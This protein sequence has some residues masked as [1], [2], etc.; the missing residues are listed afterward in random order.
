MMLVLRPASKNASRLLY[1]STSGVAAQPKTAVDVNE[2]AFVPHGPPSATFR[3]TLYHAPAEQEPRR[4]L[5][6]QGQAAPVQQPPSPVLG[7]QANG[8]LAVEVEELASSSEGAVFMEESYSNESMKQQQQQHQQMMSHDATHSPAMEELAS[9]MPVQHV[10]VN[11]C[12]FDSGAPWPVGAMILPVFWP[13]HAQQP[14]Y[15]WDS[16]VSVNDATMQFDIASV[17]SQTTACSS[18]SDAGI[19]VGTPLSGGQQQCPPSGS[20]AGLPGRTGASRRQRRKQRSA[21]LSVARESVPQLDQAPATPAAAIS[22]HVSDHREAASGAATLVVEAEHEASLQSGLP[23]LHVEAAEDSG[24][25]MLWPPTPESSPQTSPRFGTEKV[26]EMDFVLPL[27]AMPQDDSWAAQAS[28]MASPQALPMAVSAAQLGDASCESMVMQLA[29][30]DA[31]AKTALLSWL[32]NGALWPLATTPAGCRVVQKALEVSEGQEQV[33]LVEQ[34]KGHV[35]EAS[36]S[37]HANHVLQKCIELMPPDRLNFVI[38]EMR[39]HSVN[40]ARHRYGCRVLE[41]LIEHCPSWQTDELVE[42]LLVGV[43]QLCRHTF[44]NFVIQHVL[45][46]GTQSQKQRV[47]EVLFSDVQRLARHRVASHVVRSALVHCNLDDRQRLMSAMRADAGELSDL[48]HHH[49][50]SFVV[51]EMRRE[52]RR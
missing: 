27:P 28:P 9:Q 37:P 21:L 3:N 40:A 30:G 17:P 51:R 4:N 6:F 8:R 38:Q 7:W 25:S 31:S 32:A 18:L 35:R 13:V 44:G 10:D 48:A 43:S 5:P 41:R 2:G 19:S 50:G 15:S 49:C 39:G 33:A 26:F 52:L 47:C 29:A 34:M 46:H 42:E 24:P 23:L 36:T 11:G 16:G 22:D 45:E 14:Q 12:S 1:A 20:L